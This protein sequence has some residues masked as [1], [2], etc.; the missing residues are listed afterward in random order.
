MPLS[1]FHTNL[2]LRL[3][4]VVYSKLERAQPHHSSPHELLGV[5]L[6]RAGN[7][8]GPDTQYGILKSYGK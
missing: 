2:G 8:F 5:E 1:H 6:A 3:E 4:G 7:E